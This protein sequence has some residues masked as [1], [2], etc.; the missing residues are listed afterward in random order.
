[1]V[2]AGVSRRTLARSAP[3]HA[4]GPSGMSV[5]GKR[6]NAAQIAEGVRSGKSTAAAAKVDADPARAKLPLAG[7]PYAAKDNIAVTG[8]Q[9][10]CGSKILEGYISPF[11]ATA[12][13]R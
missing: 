13:E 1:V 6:L 3:R 12:I 2:R 8:L 7:V 11:T 5:H 9:V 10:T 4:R